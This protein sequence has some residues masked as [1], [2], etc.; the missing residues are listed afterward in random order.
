M[1]IVFSLRTKLLDD[2]YFLKIIF[3]SY[4]SY[5]HLFRFFS[6]ARTHLVR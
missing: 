3:V 2:N 5:P 4:V 6:C 1:T